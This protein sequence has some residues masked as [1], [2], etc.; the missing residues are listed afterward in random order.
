M[1][2]ETFSFITSLNASNPV[3]AS[4]V[5]GQGDDH[6]RGIKFTLLASFP[7]I[8]AAMTLS[9]AQLN[10]A[11][12]KNESNVFTATGSP[13]DPN[14]E[15]SNTRPL[16]AL[17]ETD[18]AANSRRWYVDVSSGSLRVA[19]INDANNDSSI[20]LEAARSGISVSSLTLRVA[21][22][23]DAIVAT[24]NGPV[25]LHHDGSRAASTH[26]AGLHVWD[27]V[28]AG[29]FSGFYDNVGNRLGYLQMGTTLTLQ[30]ESH[31]AAVSIQGEDA[32]GA[33]HSILFGDPDA[34]ATLYFDGVR[35]VTTQ[36]LG[37]DV[38]AAA[39][40]DPYIGF[41]QDGGVRNGYIQFVG[42][43]RLDIQ[44]EQNSAS[45]R[46][47][48][49]NGLG[50][51]VPLLI[52]NPDSE[53]ELYR[54]GVLRAATRATGFTV[55][56][57]G[58]AD[59]IANLVAFVWQNQ[60][61]RGY[62]G[63][64]TAGALKLENQIH[65]GAI[66]LDGENASGAGT[67]MLSADPDAAVSLYHAGTATLRTQTTALGGA[68]VKDRLGVWKK[69]GIRNPTLKTVTGNYSF[70]QDD[71]GRVLQSTEAPGRTRTCNQLEAGTC[72]RFVH[73]GAA[74]D[75]IAAGTGVTIVAYLGGL[76]VSGPL[77][78]ARDSAIE[79]YWASTT[80]VFVFGN[81]IS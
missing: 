48:S 74:N 63:Y 24:A 38:Y 57:S 11:A 16:L 42:A 49:Y 71:E 37:L 53:V 9:S 55:S 61:V 27:T 10:L 39:S 81:G 20:V 3:G 45:V 68:D 51:N 67:L 7:N 8:D 13:A 66:Q 28:G 41:W 79:L 33:V 64:D 46:L 32:G 60:S 62:V 17:N 80:T 36:T 14:V 26:A 43:N 70:I 40:D 5:K 59:N 15:L 21:D 22:N 1:P 12:I 77:T 78:L 35:S 65:G 73:R 50:S 30:S 19:A 25:T 44:A 31:G 34:G 75:T 58:N 18:A 76:E 4:D 29:P 52:G 47:R 23:E 56:S 69:V 54:A 2:L 6:L 72:I